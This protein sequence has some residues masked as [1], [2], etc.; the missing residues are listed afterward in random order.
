MWA[1]V[2]KELAVKHRKYAVREFLDA[3]GRLGLPATASRSS[4]RSATCLSR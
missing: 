3:T 2:T 4:R 1:L